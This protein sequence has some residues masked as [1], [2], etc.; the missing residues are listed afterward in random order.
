MLDLK[1][2]TAMSVTLSHEQ[3]SNGFCNATCVVSD[4]DSRKYKRGGAVAWHGIVLCLQSYRYN[5]YDDN[6]D[7]GGSPG[8]QCFPSTELS[9]VRPSPL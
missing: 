8:L 6:T 7:C 1:Y 4:S 2:G 5:N 9:P 3:T